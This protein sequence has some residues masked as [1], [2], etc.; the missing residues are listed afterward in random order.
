MAL[1]SLLLSKGGMWPWTSSYHFQ[2]EGGKVAMTSALLSLT[3]GGVWPGP[4][5]HASSRQ[6]DGKQWPRSPS[7][8]LLEGK[9]GGNHGLCPSDPEK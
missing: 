3:S 4:P 2:K 8:P 6:D 5:P 1:A 7:I 9:R